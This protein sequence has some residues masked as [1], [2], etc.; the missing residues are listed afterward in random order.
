[1]DV[2]DPF[3]EFGGF[4]SLILSMGIFF[5]CGCKRKCYINGAQ[6]LKS[7][8]HVKMAMV[9]RAMEGYVVAMLN[10]IKSL[11]PCVWILGVVHVKDMQDHPIDDLYLCISLGVEGSGFGELGVQQ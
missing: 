6:W 4:F 2:I 7:Q 8:A 9:G 11:I 1:V 10:I 3:N 5:L